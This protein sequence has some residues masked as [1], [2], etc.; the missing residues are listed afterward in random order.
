MSTEFTPGIVS[1][2]GD[3]LR[4]ELA[5]RGWASAEFA[6]IIGRPPQTVSQILN[7]KEE[8][9]ADTAVAI[10]KALGTSAELWLGLQTAYSLHPT[11]SQ[12]RQAASTTSDAGHG[13]EASSRS[14]NASRE[15][16]S[17][18]GPAT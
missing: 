2:P 10:S 14:Q 17:P 16:G 13:S 5:E 1:P 4:E 11:G 7:A 15:A 8:I 18:P 12:P 3:L 9:T 6:L